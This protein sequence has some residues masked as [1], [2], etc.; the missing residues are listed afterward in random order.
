MGGDREK[1]KIVLIIKRDSKF[2]E[3]S[4]YWNLGVD[5]NPGDI[6]KD[7]EGIATF[8]DLGRNM[9]WLL[10]KLYGKVK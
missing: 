5:F 3:V 2:K 6:L 10:K 8:R 9:A 1:A 7:K 4:K